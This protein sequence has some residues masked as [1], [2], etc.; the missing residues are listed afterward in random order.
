MIFSTGKHSQKGMAECGSAIDR[1]GEKN[2][3]FRRK[4][5]LPVVPEI[6][7]AMCGVCYPCRLLS[8]TKTGSTCAN[9]QAVRDYRGSGPCHPDDLLGDALAALRDG[10]FRAPFTRW[11]S[12]ADAL[13]GLQHQT[14]TASLAKP[15]VY[16]LKV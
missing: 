8:R 2:Q 1:R 13:V 5:S 16:P 12:L 10:I 3:A 7:A 11:T 9:S 14:R 4:R 6:A 15:N